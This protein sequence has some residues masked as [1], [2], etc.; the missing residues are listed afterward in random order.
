MTQ[1]EGGLDTVA[2]ASTPDTTADETTV[3][4]AAT[5]RR[6]WCRGTWVAVA[7]A[8]TWLG[9]VCLHLLISGRWWGWT[10][11]DLAPPLIFAVVPLLILAAPAVLRL[12]RIRMPARAVWWVAATAVVSLLLGGG[13]SGINPHALA[14]DRTS[15]A[16]PDAL[17][18]LAWNVEYWDQRVATDDVYAYLHSQQADI[19]LL[20]EYLYWVDDGPQQI[21]ELERLEQEFPD[22]EIAIVGE[23][24]T[25]SRYPIVAEHAIRLP[26]RP[27]AQYSDW[28]DYW[29]VKAQRTDIEVGTG[30][31]SFYNIHAPT[32]IDVEAGPFAGRFYQY[33]RDAHEWR[34]D[35]FDALAADVADNCHPM[36]V[37][38]DFNTTPV[39]QQVPTLD[40][41]LTDAISANRSWYPVT[42]AVP[43]NGL[44]LW[45]LD[46]AYTTD[47]VTVH[48]YEFLDQEGLSDHA[49]QR[50][51]LSL[52]EAGSTAV[53]DCAD[54]GS[55]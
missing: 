6:R 11:V 43:E 18:V 22:Y 48:E 50:L 1:P 8:A 10:F 42:F 54:P 53:G 23:L 55:E 28:D 26:S 25:I 52:D 17:Q 30:L 36:V 33:I 14:P 15:P 29:Q 20:Q 16:P 35:V 5:P 38:G 40:S 7:L 34:A 9:L 45:R 49:A 51:V 2:D 44:R 13:M 37:A 41:R 21:D 4:D 46:H 19:Y 32:P 47:E 39:M 24:V 3:D 31:L 27:A 12:V